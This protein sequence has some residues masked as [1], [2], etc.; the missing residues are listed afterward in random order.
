MSLI[1]NVHYVSIRKQTKSLD[2]K[3]LCIKYGELETIIR[4]RDEDN[5]FKGREAEKGPRK[6]R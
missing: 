3:R 6:E 1:Y 5:T 4:A 2:C